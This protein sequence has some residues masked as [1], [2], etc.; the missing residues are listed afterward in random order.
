MVLF[1]VGIVPIAMEWTALP[2][3]ERALISC[4]LDDVCHL[5]R[6]GPFGSFQT[7]GTFPERGIHGVAANCTPREYGDGEVGARGPLCRPGMWVTGWE[8]KPGEA[9]RQQSTLVT[10]L[11]PGDW[12]YI[13]LDAVWV[14][15]VAR[16]HENFQR[17]L[18]DRI[19]RLATSGQAWTLSL[20]TAPFWF[21][22]PAQVGAIA[23][24]PF[25]LV[26]VFRRLKFV[27]TS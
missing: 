24:L 4:D 26:F 1:M 3:G 13:P 22:F 7:I 17:E 2:S 14:S 8:G 21:P 15:F 9:T 16:Q 11:R 19:D 23:V 20:S 12:G 10:D 25:V 5:R 27:C 18:G 6:A